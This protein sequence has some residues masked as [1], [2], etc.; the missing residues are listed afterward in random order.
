MFPVLYKASLLPPFFWIKRRERDLAQGSS[1]FTFSHMQVLAGGSFS[2]GGKN[3]FMNTL[4]N[5]LLLPALQ[6]YLRGEQVLWGELQVIV[7]AKATQNSPG[8]LVPSSL[9]EKCV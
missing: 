7:V 6:W 3:V 5:P 8:G 2:K 9:N 1:S 4:Q